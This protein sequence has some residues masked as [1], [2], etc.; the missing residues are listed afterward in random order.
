LGER[1]SGAK[2]KAL[3]RAHGGKKHGVHIREAGQTG[4]A[5]KGV[6]PKTFGGAG[7]N[8]TFFRNRWRGG[9][10]FF[11]SEKNSENAEE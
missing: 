4:R 1:K 2:E 7:H 11:E 5:A 10:Y 3:Y 8:P 6:E 9:I